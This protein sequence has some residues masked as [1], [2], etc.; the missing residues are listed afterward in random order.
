MSNICFICCG[1]PTL[2]VGEQDSV[3][4]ALP[5]LVDENSVRVVVILSSFLA[6]SLFSLYCYFWGR[7]LPHCFVVHTV[8]N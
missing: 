2:Y 8:C 7:L 1:S 5:S 3:V 6:W 4:Y